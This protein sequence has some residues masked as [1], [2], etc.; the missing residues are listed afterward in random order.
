MNWP[1]WRSLPPL[2]TLSSACFLRPSMRSFPVS[3]LFVLLLSVGLLACESD[4]DQSSPSEA[5]RTNVAARD[6]LRNVTTFDDP[7]PVPDVTVETLDGQTID[8]GAQS[9]TVLLVNFWATWCPPCR[10]EIPDLVA[11]QKELGP[12]G[13]TILGVST[14]QEG[15]EAVRPFVD[16]Y[17]INYP[18]VVDTT[19]SLQESS[20]G[21]V[22]GLPTTFVVNADGQVVQRVM[23]M[24]PVEAMKPTLQK[25][26]TE[27]GSS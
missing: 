17:D 13:F 27:A 24:F 21:P 9:G 7:K 8:L 10:E 25:L 26:L 18:I 12:Q 6:S 3:G 20:L 16:E 19:R 11:L 22:Y 4:S 14:D 23:G 1:R 2:L 5:P 15:A